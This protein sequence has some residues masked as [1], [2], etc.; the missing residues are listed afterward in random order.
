MNNSKLIFIWYDFKDTL[1]RLFRPPPAVSGRSSTF[2]LGAFIF[3]FFIFPF[4][5]IFRL[6]HD[7]FDSSN[8]LFPYRFPLLA[9]ICL[10]DRF[11]NRCMLVQPSYIGTYPSAT[12]YFIR[13]CSIDRGCVVFSPLPY[14]FFKTPNLTVIYTAT[15]LQNSFQLH[16][17]VSSESEYIAN[18]R[19]FP[20]TTSFPTEDV[21]SEHR[22]TDS[23][24]HQLGH[25]S[26]VPVTNGFRY[27]AQHSAVQYVP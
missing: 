5:F 10:P 3:L 27:A 14:E 16:Y 9:L 20:T 6:C 17:P 24:G 19:T 22:R 1:S 15:L 26:S 4:L 2:S 18:E 12:P 25:P 11:P 23:L 8:I 21:E 7:L 13:I